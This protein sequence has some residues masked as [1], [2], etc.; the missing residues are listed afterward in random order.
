MFIALSTAQIHRRARLRPESK[1]KLLHE[2]CP[3]GTKLGNSTPPDY[4]LALLLSLVLVPQKKKIFFSPAQFGG[5][6]AK[7]M[8]GKLLTWGRTYI[9]IYMGF[10]KPLQRHAILN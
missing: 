5:T 9:Y 10:P 3:Q 4:T 8:L 2:Q 7:A 1:Q 6:V